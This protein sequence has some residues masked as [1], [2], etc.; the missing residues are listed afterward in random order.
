MGQQDE[1]HW[2]PRYR[3]DRAQNPD[4]GPDEAHDA[5]AP[6]DGGLWR[7]PETGRAGF[8]ALDAPLPAPHP[9]PDDAWV[10]APARTAHTAQ[11]DGAPAPDGAGPATRPRRPVTRPRG[12]GPRRPPVPHQ[13]APRPQTP[14]ELPTWDGHVN[15]NEDVDLDELDPL[16]RARRRAALEAA[17]RAHPD[18]RRRKALR[19]LAGS[20][21]ALVLAVAGVGTYAYEHLFG[22]VATESLDS[23]TNRPAFAK[24]DRFGH[25]PLNIL[26]LGSQTRDGQH[27]LNLGN[28]TKLGTDISDTAMLVHI[29]AERKWATVVSIP[30]DLVVPRPECPGRLDPTQTVPSSPDAMFDLAMNLGGPTCAVATVEQM[31][32]IRI[33]HFVEINFNAFQALTDAVGGVT[34]CVPSPGINDPHYSGLVLGPGLHTVSGPESLAFVRDRHGLADGTDLNRIRMQQMFVSSL[35]DKLAS[36]GTL[37]DPITL[38][39]IISAVTN[40]LTVDTELDSI[41]VMVGLAGSV[42]SLESHYIQFITVPYGFDPT[43]QNRVIPGGGF[44]QVWTDLREDAPL[45]G[46]NAADAFGT[47]AT[48]A[49]NP[50][51]GGN[52]PQP[53]ANPSAAAHSLAGLDVEVYN[54]TQTPHLALYSSENLA[55]MGAQAAVGQSEQAAARYDGLPGT[56]VLYPTGE[57]AQAHELA[58]AI[59]GSV[60]TLQSPN[61]RGLTLVVGPNAPAALVSEPGHVADGAAANAENPRGNSSNGASTSDDSSS[62]DN[63]SSGDDASAATG[64]PSISTE[65]RSGDEDICSDLP[66]TVAYGGRP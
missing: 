20:C 60:T 46:S 24:A 42:Q 9:A 34:V 39:K 62:S 1:D 7:P 26:V 21:A 18:P 65:S 66:D 23:L 30:R 16:G 28:A 8:P 57:A 49:P 14:V 22:A 52:G 27:G 35:F 58:D 29:S 64:A 54:G 3:P 61:V 43:D 38:Y 48:A 17:R 56:E 5:G 37:G 63:P 25:V 19:V 41:D 45:P 33:D 55:A 15:L 36:A 2:Y 44:D 53:G 13:P 11:P 51:P 50:N 31:T 40:N 4:P 12:R 32:G 6:D 59:G 10:P 47:A